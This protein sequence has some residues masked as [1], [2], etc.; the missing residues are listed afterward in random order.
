M[1]CKEPY[2]KT[3]KT[4]HGSVIIKVYDNLLKDRSSASFSV[5]LF[6]AHTKLAGDQ[7]QY[8]LYEI[9]ALLLSCLCIYEHYSQHPQCFQ[10]SLASTVLVVK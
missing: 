2:I 8:D 6:L 5:H 7:K 1:T 9:E 4:I 10:F 3:Q